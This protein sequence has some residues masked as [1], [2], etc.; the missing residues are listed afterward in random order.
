MTVYYTSMASPLGELGIA[1]DGDA[2]T[3]V[4]MAG[5]KN[6]PDMD[7]WQFNDVI[8]ANAT[9]QLTE[10]FSG[11]RVAFDL[12][13][14][15]AGTSFQQRVWR[16][17]QTIPLGDTWSYKALATAVGKPAAARAVGAANGRNPIAI[18]VPCHRVIG[19]NGSTTGYAGGVERKRWLLNHE[20]QA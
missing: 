9:Q 8:F 19:S 10:Y 13:L 11:K 2:I 20:Q 17:L 4:W 15:P 7:H 5:Q 6:I 14:K 18:I 1:G 12:P 3:H 16:M